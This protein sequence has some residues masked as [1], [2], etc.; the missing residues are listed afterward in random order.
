MKSTWKVAGL[1]FVLVVL[2]IIYSMISEIHE[3]GPGPGSES[4]IEGNEYTDCQEKVKQEIQKVLN[5]PI[6]TTSET[7]RLNSQEMMNKIKQIEKDV[8]NGTGVFEGNTKKCFPKAVSMQIMLPESRTDVDE[9]IRAIQ[10]YL[11]TP[12]K[13]LE[14]SS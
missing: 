7:P 12:Q 4:F 5:A 2:T 8:K 1:L 13:D 14:G 11:T 10:D 9:K 3:S 6:A